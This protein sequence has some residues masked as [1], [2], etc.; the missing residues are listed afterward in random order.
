[1]NIQFW[2]NLSNRFYDSKVAHDYKDGKID[3]RFIREWFLAQASER[4]EFPEFEDV[5]DNV[6]GISDSQIAYDV[7]EWLRDWVQN[8]EIGGTEEVMDPEV[9]D[10]CNCLNSLEGIETFNSCCGRGKDPMRI[11]FRVHNNKG[12]F[13]LTRSVDKR[14]WKYDW[15]ITLSVG[16]IYDENGYPLY[17][18][19][20]S[21]DVGENCYTQA[22]SLID[23]INYHL[24]HEVFN[25]YFHL[26]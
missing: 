15:K 22:Q 12:L 20:E 11:W 10:L 18:L 23:N 1:M 24:D 9:V 17:Y 25:E 3:Y 5:C 26:K 8:V 16:D 2:E 6:Q 13:I 21:T 7:Y 14:Y 19:L 4:A